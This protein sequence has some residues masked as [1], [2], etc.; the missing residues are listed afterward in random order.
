MGGAQRVGEQGKTQGYAGRVSYSMRVTIPAWRKCS[1]AHRRG[2]SN[3][4]N[5]CMAGV[6]EREIIVKGI[7]HRVEGELDI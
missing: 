2:L 4:R 3:Q 6:I 1:A 5:F 7:I